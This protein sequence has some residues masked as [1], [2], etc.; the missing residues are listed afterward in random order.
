MTVGGQLQACQDKAQH[1]TQSAQDSVLGIADH[2]TS[3][4]GAPSGASSMESCWESSC[5]GSGSCSWSMN[6]QP[7][8]GGWDLVQISQG[9]VS[10]PKNILV[11]TSM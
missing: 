10:D 6:C 1:A 9:T 8:T 5:D 11:S 3:T 2:G 7:P 4:Y